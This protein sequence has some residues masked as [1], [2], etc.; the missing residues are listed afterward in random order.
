MAKEQRR[1]NREARK[2]KQQKAP[3]RVEATLGSQVKQAG[4]GNMPRGNG[5]GKS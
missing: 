1:S 2:P 4:N 3:A 5:K